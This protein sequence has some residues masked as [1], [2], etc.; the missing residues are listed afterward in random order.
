VPDNGPDPQGHIRFGWRGSKPLQPGI[1]N[2]GG[3]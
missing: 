1:I 2:G 3:K